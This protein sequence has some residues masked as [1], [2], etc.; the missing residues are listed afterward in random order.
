MHDPDD[1]CVS[2]GYNVDIDAAALEFSALEPHGKGPQNNHICIA[3]AMK[4]TCI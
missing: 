3:Q 1:A 2:P 4:T